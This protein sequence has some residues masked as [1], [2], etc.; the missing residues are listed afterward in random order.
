MHVCMCACVHVVRVFVYVCMC[1][2]VCVCKSARIKRVRAGGGGVGVVWWV[3][4]WGHGKAS[5]GEQRRCEL[6]HLDHIQN[7]SHYFALHPSTWHAT[8]GIS[9]C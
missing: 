4:V 3:V 6:P 2:C 9:L 7:T 5:T 8:R 1:V